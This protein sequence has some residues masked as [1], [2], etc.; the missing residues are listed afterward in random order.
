MTIIAVDDEKMALQVISTAIKEALPQAQ[1]YCF[2][3]PE[4]AIS[5]MEENLC[6]IAFLDID[7]PTISGI[8]LAK[9]LKNINPKVNIVFVTAHSAY[10]SQAISVHF[11]GYVLKPATKDK[12]ETEIRNLR[13]PIDEN[14]E[15]RFWI[16]CFGNFEVFANGAPITF[17]H[18]KT[19]ELLA[20]LVD[21]LG[22]YCSNKE[23]IAALWEDTESDRQKESYLRK[24]KS[25][26]MMELHKAGINNALYKKRGYLAINTKAIECDY[27]Q[28][29]NNDIKAINSYRGEYMVQYSWSEFTKG[30]LELNCNKI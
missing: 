4:K 29:L 9:E 10:A 12:I 14:E 28:W 24:L 2:I 18:E 30:A 21:R 8:D 20:Y 16:R 22:A 7:M 6:E 15:K 1:V 3:N 27:F 17:Q 25:D 23:I 13:F 11:S 19:K 5:F 26:L